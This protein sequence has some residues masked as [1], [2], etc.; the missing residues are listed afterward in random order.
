MVMLHEIHRYIQ[1]F[2]PYKMIYFLRHKFAFLYLRCLPFYQH[3][4]KLREKYAFKLK[5]KNIM[6]TQV[7]KKIV[8]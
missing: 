8:A 2:M 7:K 1:N 4:R 3:F 6:I 5:I